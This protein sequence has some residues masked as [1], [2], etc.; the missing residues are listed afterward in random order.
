HRV[1]MIQETRVVISERSRHLASLL[2]TI[3]ELE[4]HQRRELALWLGRKQVLVARYRFG[5]AL[6]QIERVCDLELRLRRL[7]RARGFDDERFGL[8]SRLVVVFELEVGVGNLQTCP[9]R[10]GALRELPHQLL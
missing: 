3:S 8:F 5:V 2:E 9:Q 1:R 7:V 10:L 4:E 6:L